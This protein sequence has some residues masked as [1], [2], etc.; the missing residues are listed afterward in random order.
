MAFV[1][2]PLPVGHYIRV[3]RSET[4]IF[5]SEPKYSFKVICLD[6]KTREPYRAVSYTWDKPPTPVSTIN[7]SDGQ[8]LVLSQTLTDLFRAM[9]KRK[10]SFSIW[11]DA[12]CIN[13]DDPVEK[14]FQVG[15]MDKV[16]S[17][18][19]YVLLWLGAGTPE[20]HEAFRFMRSKRDLEW[21]DDRWANL[22]QEDHGCLELVLRML[23]HPWFRRTW[24]I[25][26]AT[27]SNNVWM[28]CGDEIV[29]FATFSRCIFA[30]WGFFTEW[31]RYDYD[32]PATLG[33]WSV[34]RL[35][36]FR[37]EFLFSGKGLKWEVLLQAAFRCESSDH[38]DAVFAFR[39]IA[40]RTQPVPEPEYTVPVGKEPE[41]S[42]SVER[43]YRETAA[44]LLCHGTSLDLLA[45]GG[46]ERVR[47][48]TLATWV[49]DLRHFSYTEPYVVC[50]AAGWNAGG[51]LK[52]CPKILS[53]N[54]LQ[55]QVVPVDTVEATYPE[56]DMRSIP[57]Q[58]KMM[59]EI[60]AFWEARSKPG[61]SRESWQNELAMDMIFGLDIDDVRAGPEYLEAFTE[62][63][64]WLQASKSHVDLAEIKR[65]KYYR[66]LDVRV[67]GWKAFS[68][69][70]GFFCIGPLEVE[71]GDTLCVVPGC[72]L[73]LLLR[74]EPDVSEGGSSYGEFCIVS[75]C[76]ASR[77]MAGGIVSQGL[78]SVD[79]VLV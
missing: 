30:V 61:V 29:G 62:W 50:D 66:V 5:R 64:E 71:A 20:T 48:P 19:S 70:H 18:A 34:T 55:T 44:A 54:R 38:R 12:L 27:L 23:A 45:L 79:V 28:H 17:S 6:D 74:Q 13:Q 67:G 39:G 43:V 53:H 72:R 21:P 69:Q 11:I 16:Y 31:D 2:K 1:Y 57:R 76:Y 4:Q 3:L 15:M 59:Q 46:L 32:H 40:D 14:A 26:E 35:I 33:L 77:L 37:D 24:V 75:W 41:Y 7:L 10:R 78:D 63:L 9:R 36:S 25:Q 52:E 60:L 47:S 49:P 73:P 22:T 8:S 68:T 56:F 42:E 65:N 51:P 58:Q